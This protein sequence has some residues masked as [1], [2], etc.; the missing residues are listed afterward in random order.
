[1]LEVT[2]AQAL[3]MISTVA[4][5]GQRPQLH[6]LDRIENDGVIIKKT[7]PKFTKIP[8]KKE[9]FE[10]LIEGLFKVVNEEGTAKR[11]KI[12]GY[13][14][15]GKTGTQ[16]IISKENPRYKEL[17]KIRRFMPHAWFVSFAPKENPRYAS[18]IFIENGGG[19]GTIAAPL[20]KDIY[21]RLFEK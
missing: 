17:V 10:L 11:A 2:P 12:K 20:A 5:R 13:D 1:M 6:L 18:V 14:I 3:L 7:E 15:C 4:L 21:K 19:A 16:Q 9:S 8:I